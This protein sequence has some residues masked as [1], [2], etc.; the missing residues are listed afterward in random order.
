MAQKT[1]R[2]SL[3][4]VWE[5]ISLFLLLNW[6]A[7]PSQSTRRA[8]TYWH[9][10]NATWLWHHLCFD[11]R[12][13]CFL[14]RS[15]IAA[16]SLASSQQADKR[17]WI[18]SDANHNGETDVKTTDRHFS[19]FNWHPQICPPPDKRRLLTWQVC[20]NLPEEAGTRA[21]APADTIRDALTLISLKLGHCA[22]VQDPNE[23]FWSRRT[24]SISLCRPPG[25]GAKWK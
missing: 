23:C 4:P 1:A 10:C 20:L 6:P 15:L 5:L 11:H 8:H 3:P 7:T 17:A 24:K 18:L 25:R 21:H 14:P 2:P 12:E 13:T 19:A 22:A 16:V 9:A